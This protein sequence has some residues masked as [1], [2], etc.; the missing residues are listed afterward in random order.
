MSNLYVRIALVAALI[1]GLWYSYNWAYD[2]GVTAERG[3]WT[4]AQNEELIN[5]NKKYAE[6]EYNYGILVTSY[7]DIY[8]KGLKDGQTKK[9]DVI[10][11]VNNGT[12]VLRDKNAVRCPEPIITSDAAP[13]RR[14]ASEGAELSR[15]LTE[16][17]IGLTTEADDVVRQLTTCQ[18]D[19]QALYDV[20]SPRQV[21]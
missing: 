12:L 17:L 6:L 2:N 8:Q 15:P 7:S 20:C 13:G 14:D 19:Y 16:F 21:F 10:T 11:R 3:V 9:S 18:K 5:A 1:A 4:S